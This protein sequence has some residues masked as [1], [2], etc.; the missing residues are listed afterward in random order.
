MG[1]GGS[2]GSNDEEGCTGVDENGRGDTNRLF[3][4]HKERMSWSEKTK[5]EKSGV[6][7]NLDEDI[8][9]ESIPP[10]QANIL[11]Q[12]V[13]RRKRAMQLL[14]EAAKMGHTE[15]MTNLG[16]MNE[17]MGY[18]EEAR[19]WYRYRGW[20]DVKGNNASMN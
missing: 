7:A 1:S 6:H 16:N 14:Q 18:L 15:A 11:D 10:E 12:V 2:G 8:E 4:E 19:T 13:G 5:E 17:A 9:M 20:V 3:D